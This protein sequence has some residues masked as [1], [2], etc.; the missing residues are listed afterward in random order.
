MAI[1]GYNRVVTAA[2]ICREHCSLRL[3]DAL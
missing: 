3:V 1:Q 2:V